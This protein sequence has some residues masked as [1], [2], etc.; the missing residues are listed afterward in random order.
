ME[1]SGTND[2]ITR[3]HQRGN[4]ESVTADLE[5]AMEGR[6][7]RRAARLS[8]EAV[9]RAARLAIERQARDD[10][11]AQQREDVAVKL[12]EQRGAER[13]E[14][15]MRITAVEK[16]ALAVNGKFDRIDRRLEGQDEKLDT[17]V[18][19]E[20]A[21]VARE[22]ERTRELAA[23]TEKQ[24]SN[25]AFFVGVLTLL[26]PLLVLILQQQGAFK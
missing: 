6:G 24:I 21:R 4:R 13:A 26:V 22:Q 20:K 10:L 7:A 23:A 16:H 17:L 1:A 9:E 15:H 8:E 18:A 25:R 5:E 2:D 11:A 12:A 3:G 19:S 14:T